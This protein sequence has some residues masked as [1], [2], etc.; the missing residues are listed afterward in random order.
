MSQEPADK[1]AP[2]PPVPAGGPL[3]PGYSEFGAALADFV[4]P[5]PGVRGAILTDVE[6]DPVDFAHRTQEVGALDLQIAGAQVEQATLRVQ[7]W[8]TRLGLGRCEILIEASH[9][10]ILS[11][12]PGGGCVLSSLHRPREDDDAEALLAGFAALHRRITE[13]IA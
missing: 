1:P 4:A 13:L 8:S 12:A 11:A 6:G 7:A 10:L 5:R 9:G 3:F 2:Q